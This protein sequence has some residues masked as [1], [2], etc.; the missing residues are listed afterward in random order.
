M[1]VCIF[2][3]SLTGRIEMCASKRGKET[4]SNEKL[5][6]ISQDTVRLITPYDPF[7]S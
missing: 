2:G 6:L 1:L 3:L 5:E 7:K 4:E